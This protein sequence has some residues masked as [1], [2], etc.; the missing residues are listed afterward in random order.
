MF[1]LIDVI[2]PFHAVAI[3]ESVI[4]VQSPFGHPYQFME[5][6]RTHI[7]G[8]R[9]NGAH[10]RPI[11]SKMALGLCSQRALL[12]GPNDEDLMMKFCEFSAYRFQNGSISIVIR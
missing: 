5:M 10:F 6:R 11:D 2:D 8:F 9:F 1:I 3:L 12:L 4:L 7:Y